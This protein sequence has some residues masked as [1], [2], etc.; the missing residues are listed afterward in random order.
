MTPPDT[1]ALATKLALPKVEAEPL[2][3]RART[4]LQSLAS[5]RAALVHDTFDAQENLRTFKKVV[6]RSQTDLDDSEGVAID[7]KKSLKA[8]KAQRDAILT[9]FKELVKLVTSVYAPLLT[10]LEASEKELKLKLVKGLAALTA[11]QNRALKT[12]STLTSA[13]RIAP[14]RQVLLNM[15]AAERPKN[16]SVRE[17][18][19]F[20]ILDI[21]KVE[22]KY[23]VAV[24]NTDA[25]EAA[26]EAGV[27][28]IE[29]LQIYKEDSVT[30]RTG[31]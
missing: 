1:E 16:M 30:L 3:A 21:S 6:I 11:E 20:R 4:S 2:L 26:I 17:I 19:K 12:I 27:R 18:W 31:G 24:V 10:S 28:R 7:V 9:P 25:V 15:P 13:G 22:D 23:L 29:G 5:A 8:A 14:A